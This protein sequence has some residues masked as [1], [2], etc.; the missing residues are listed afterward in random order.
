M[1]GARRPAKL[2]ERAH[3]LRPARLSVTQAVCGRPAG[4]CARE[5]AEAL[6]ASLA[7]ARR[8]LGG[9]VRALAAR[10]VSL[11]PHGGMMLLQR[12][13]GQ[14]PRGR[15]PETATKSSAVRAPP[16][17]LG[18][19]QRAVAR[20]TAAARRPHA[21]HRHRAD[22]ADAAAVQPGPHL[23][24]RRH[25]AHCPGVWLGARTAGERASSLALAYELRGCHTLL[26]AQLP[27]AGLLCAARSL[28]PARLARQGVVQSAFLWGYMA[29]QLL[30][31]TLADRFGGALAA[32]TCRTLI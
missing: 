24:E 22:R 26:P 10:R 32:P 27:A 7:L 30:G 21:A 29:T 5:A 2:A 25:C 31:G 20:P 6:P 11:V 9:Q 1:P 23:P 3:R 17:G 16:C 15:K 12:A 18:G 14:A 8:E 19:V 4:H 28:S 13:A